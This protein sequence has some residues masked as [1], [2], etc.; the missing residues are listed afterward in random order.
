MVWPHGEARENASR[1]TIF[2]AA[3]RTRSHHSGDN[4]N[5]SK[6][7]L[8][9][10]NAHCKLGISGGGAMTVPLPRLPVIPKDM[11]L[12]LHD[13]SSLTTRGML[14]IHLQGVGPRHHSFPAQAAV[15]LVIGYHHLYFHM[16]PSLAIMIPPSQRD[17][18]RG[19]RGTRTAHRGTPRNCSTTFGWAGPVSRAK[20]NQIRKKELY[21]C[22]TWPC[23]IAVDFSA[24]AARA[25]VW[26]SEQTKKL[27]QSASFAEWLLASVLACFHVLLTSAGRSPT[28]SCNPI[29]IFIP[30]PFALRIRPSH[31]HVIIP[32]SLDLPIPGPA[33]CAKRLNNITHTNNTNDSSHA[34]TADNRM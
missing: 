4:G 20:R 12:C 33:E 5:G 30:C 2:A 31:H 24:L 25:T 14:E 26:G 23:V 13:T 32:S 10:W 28:R 18:R 11:S 16:H 3:W 22:M 34:K 19:A 27:V 29:L 1:P 9:S 17:T 7:E 6:R 15:P 21:S 8:P